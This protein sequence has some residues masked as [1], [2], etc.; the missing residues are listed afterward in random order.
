MNRFYNNYSQFLFSRLSARTYKIPLNIN[1]SCPNRDGSKSQGGCRFC[2]SA[3][4]G[5][6][7][8]LSIEQQIQAFRKNRN[9][10]YIGYLQ[11]FC[12]MYGETDKLKDVFREILSHP[13]LDGI[14]VATRPD[15]VNP[16]LLEYLSTFSNK[17]IQ[18]ELGLESVNQ[19]ALDSMNRHD[20]PESFRYAVH[21]IQELCPQ[22]H[23]VGHMIIGLPH[24]SN[25]G[26]IRTAN[27]I[28]ETGAQGIKIHNLYIQRDMDIYKD[29]MRGNLELISM[30]DYIETV[31]TVLEHI[32]PHMVIHRL[33]SASSPGKLIAPLWTLD[34]RFYNEL[35]NRALMRKS[36]QGKTY[37]NNDYNCW[38]KA[39]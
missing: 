15:T 13:S 21:M 31:L 23:T 34:S 37:G 24:D 8:N 1:S 10:K 18:I 25:D 14:S 26:Y 5:T 6:G 16:E 4:S 30:H 38:Q 12:N 19:T 22:A 35:Q 28:E 33:K 3:G 9:E 17:F 2:S 27:F 32:K 36:Y 7:S 29:F 11:S 39:E 20:T